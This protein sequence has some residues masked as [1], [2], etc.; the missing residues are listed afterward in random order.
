MCYEYIS[1]L[2]TGLAY[3]VLY[4][5]LLHVHL[6]VGGSATQ[7]VG[8]IYWVQ[9]LSY[10]LVLCPHLGGCGPRAHM[11]TLCMS[12]CCLFTASWSC[13]SM[14]TR[15]CSRALNC[16]HNLCSSWTNRN[17][18]S[19]QAKN[20]T[21]RRKRSNQYIRKSCG[22]DVTVQLLGLNVVGSDHKWW[23]SKGKR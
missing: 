6:W 22:N 21:C 18:Q 19:I 11:L 13:S 1:V 17:D 15:S 10:H 14:S 12:S 23:T 3:W 20:V 7:T 2:P 5:H 16:K 4:S 8:G 9:A